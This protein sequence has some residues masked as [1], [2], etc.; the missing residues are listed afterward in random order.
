MLTKARSRHCSPNNSLTV[1]LVHTAEMDGLKRA[2]QTAEREAAGNLHMLREVQAQS[3]R[4]AQQQA[5]VIRQQ[6]ECIQRLVRDSSDYTEQNE[7]I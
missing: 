4:G 1:L 7:A 6:Q 5:E 2:L 3:A